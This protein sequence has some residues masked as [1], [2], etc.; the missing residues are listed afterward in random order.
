M[1]KA[2]FN[3]EKVIKMKVGLRE[4]LFK[5]S[6]YEMI[7][8]GFHKQIVVK[9]SVVALENAYLNI[10]SYA[11]PEPYRYDEASEIYRRNMLEAECKKAQG[12]A[13]CRQALRCC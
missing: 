9:P 4:R 11:P 10:A 5:K 13:A 12:I 6:L 3:Y 7:K 8:G 1:I 2:L